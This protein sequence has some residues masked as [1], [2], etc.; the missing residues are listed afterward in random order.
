M[1][2]FESC[3]RCWFDFRNQ[4]LIKFSGKPKSGV[5]NH[6]FNLVL[7]FRKDGDTWNRQILIAKGSIVESFTP[8]ASY[9]AKL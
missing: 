2:R 3:P 5:C 7:T 8:K 4:S 6:P 9:R 1:C